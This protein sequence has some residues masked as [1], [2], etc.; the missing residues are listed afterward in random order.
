MTYSQD[1]LAKFYCIVT[2]SSGDRIKSNEVKVIETKGIP[3]SG[4][5]E[6]HA[7]TGKI[8]AGFERNTSDT[9]SNSGRTYELGNIDLGLQERPKAQLMISKEITNAKVILANG[10]VLFDASGRATNVTWHDKKTHEY[11]YNGRLMKQPKVNSGSQQVLLTMDEELMHGANINITYKISVKNI[12]EV[13][14]PSKEFYYAGEKTEEDNAV[15]T[16]VGDIVDYAGASGAT[17]TKSVYNN[18]KF[19]ANENTGWTLT[20]AG[21]LKKDG[22]V[23]INDTSGNDITNNINKYNT[24]LKYSFNQDLKPDKESS[25]ES[26]IDATLKLSQ[27]ITPDSNSDDQKYSNMVE[28][29]SYKNGV[30]RKMAY[31][32]VGNQDP[33]NKIAEADADL[34]QLTILPPFGQRYGYYILGISIATIAIA[35]IIIIKKKVLKK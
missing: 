24:I 9:S 5:Y 33:D 11:G 25:E 26:T 8:Y 20:T 32:T 2:N 30:G 1:F 29:L 34:S 35:G 4:R 16:T 23:Q 28:I 19:N 31:S 15:A 22:L 21:D 6:M 10:S 14:Y 27:V 17:D 12:G 7:V 13:D 3:T 18:L